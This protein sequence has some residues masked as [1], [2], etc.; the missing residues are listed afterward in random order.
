VEYKLVKIG[1]NYYDHPIP[2]QRT[3]NF[4]LP[5]AYNVPSDQ[6]DINTPT[7]NVIQLSDTPGLH[8]DFNA[9]RCTMLSVVS[10]TLSIR[11]EHF[12]TYLGTLLL[13]LDTILGYS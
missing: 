8:V 3:P 1:Y 7:A 2:M 12:L 4:P 11:F 9:L 6:L 13:L 10:L 5:P